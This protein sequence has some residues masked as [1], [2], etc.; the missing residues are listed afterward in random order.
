MTL[1]RMTIDSVTLWHRAELWIDYGI[2]I[3]WVSFG[4][5]SYWFKSFWWVPFWYHSDECHFNER[6]SDKSH[7]DE[8]YSAESHTAEC[9]T[10][11]SHCTEC[12]SPILYTFSVVPS[13]VNYNLK[14]RRS[15]KTKCSV[16]LDTLFKSMSKKAW[17]SHPCFL[18][19]QP[20]F[21][22]I[23]TWNWHILS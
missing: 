12:Y 2:L 5:V 22:L 17:P 18:S 11:E 15:F 9:H 13:V 7:S 23:N 14:K 21:S 10:A 4:W 19:I 16:L 1:C 3:C 8:C 6:H 20:H